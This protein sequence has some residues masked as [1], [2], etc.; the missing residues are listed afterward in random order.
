MTHSL[1]VRCAIAIAFLCCLSVVR[2]VAQGSSGVAGVVISKQSG[3]PVVGAEVS[4][5]GGS[6]RATTD[7][8]GRF[9][10]EGLPPG[11]VVLVVKAPGF[12]ELRTAELS[13]RSGEPTQATI[14]LE[15]TP[16]Y[17]ERVQVTAT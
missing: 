15:P 6:Q 5:E 10:L 1:W 13:A 12:L 17:L 2:I 9:R 14:E 11:R 7:G 16:N 8:G 4:V 3:Q